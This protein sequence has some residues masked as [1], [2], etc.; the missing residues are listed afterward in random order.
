M[1]HVGNNNIN[2]GRMLYLIKSQELRQESY[3]RYVSDVSKR[4]LLSRFRLG[5]SVLRIETGRY[6]HNGFP[7]GKGLPLEWRVCLCSDRRFGGSWK[8]KFIS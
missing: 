1:L 4:K 8:M 6:E 7:G 2:A 3:L 5:M